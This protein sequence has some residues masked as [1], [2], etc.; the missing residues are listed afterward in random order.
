MLRTSA[1]STQSL[2]GAAQS[3]NEAGQWYLVTMSGCMTARHRRRLEKLGG[4]AL[5]RPAAPLTV[6]PSASIKLD[7]SPKLLEHLVARGALL[8]LE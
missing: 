2:P 7:D 1:P 3:T 8:V 6:R 4:P 5:E